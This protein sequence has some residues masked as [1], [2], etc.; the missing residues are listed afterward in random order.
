MDT[1]ASPATYSQEAATFVALMRDLMPRLQ[2]DYS[3][4]SMQALEA[5]IAEQFDPPGSTFVGDQLPFSIGCYVGEVIVRTLGGAWNS[6]GKPEINQLG[7]IKAIFP[8]QKVVKRFTNGPEDSLS[9][10]YTLITRYASGEA[11]DDLHDR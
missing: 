1:D 7:P 2:L 11:V 6:E 10:Y 3:A 9:W 8:M 4:A 5:L